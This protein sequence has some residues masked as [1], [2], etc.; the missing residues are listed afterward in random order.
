MNRTLLFAFIATAFGSAALAD[1]PTV[2]PRLHSGG[3]A[4]R[5]KNITFDPSAQPLPL[6]NKELSPTDKNIIHNAEQL[7]DNNKTTALLL[8]EKGKIVFEKY[9]EPAT[10]NSPLFSQSMSKSLT[11]YAFG[12]VTCSGK[13][14]SLDDRADKYA[15]TLKG[16][17]F[18]EATIRNLLR[19]SS[20]TTIPTLA[21]SHDPK[22][23]FNLR[24]GVLTTVDI[25]H[26][27]SNT[28]QDPQGS[29]FNYSSTDPWSIQ[30]VAQGAG[31][32][33]EEAFRKEIWAKA[34]TESTGFWLHDK[35]G[36]LL[37][38]AGFSATARDWAR[39]AIYTIKTLQGENGACMQDYMKQA[40]SQQIVNKSGRIGRAFPGYGFQ[41]WIADF[42]G[43]K[44]Y[45]WSGYGGQRVG[46]DPK[47]EKIMVITSWKEDY[48]REVYN[49]FV[50]WQ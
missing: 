17:I 8:I 19:M 4:Y 11:A 43:K 50:K 13:I 24:D 38:Q 49:L 26:G 39:L 16:T 34:R 35:S 7:I 15:Q 37:A 27:Q 1:T 47:S 48:M 20:G 21:G 29:V 46:I 14:R 45:W 28:R 23:W 22:E 25:L 33:I 2:N 3:L 12:A 44:S 42:R 31:E 18:G 40:T 30:E 41:T 10:R 36:R 9:K 6:P 32:T 5:F